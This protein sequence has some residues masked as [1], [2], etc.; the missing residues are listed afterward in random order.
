MVIARQG[1]CANQANCPLAKSGEVFTI[2]EGADFHCPLCGSELE[3]TAAKPPSKLRRRFL[4][5]GAVALLL[6]LC[7][8]AVSRRW[9][10]LSLTGIAGSNVGGNTILRLAGSNTIGDSLGPSLAAAFLKD[11]GATN[12]RTLPGDKAD[13]KI[14]QGVLP[15]DASVSSIDIA[16]H[17]SATAFKAFEENSC[18]I[19]MASRRINATEAAKL[20]SIGDFYSAGSEHILGL[21]GI[22]VIVN[23]SNP[24]SELSV[25]QIKRIFTGQIT[26]WSQVGSSH[27]AIGIYARNDNSGTYDTFKSLVLA[28]AAL[29]ASAHRFEDSNALSA[30]VS[31]DPNGIGFIGLPFV[32]SA[33]AVSVSE[34]GTRA[35]QPTRLTVATEDYALARRLYLYTPANP[36][37]K[38]SRMLI[39]FALSKQGQDVVEANG[40]V[41]QN[42]VPESQQVSANAPIDYRQLTQNAGRLPLDFRF[43]P[44]S[45]SWT[46]RLR[47]IW[48]GWWP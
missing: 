10:P 18:D 14:V 30:A 8:V 19:G 31:G 20:R 25:D 9:I 12:I 26:D 47:P 40:F 13:E 36:R 5:A 32:H 35:L 1:R 41:A 43:M 17:G 46:T 23:T 34:Q 15:G 6:L 37:N 22:A 16:A 29:S 2:P 48:T 38:F 11:L 4:T 3:E 27:G 39:T 7:L 45:R 42:A 33:K 24:V 44:A 21:D 28:G